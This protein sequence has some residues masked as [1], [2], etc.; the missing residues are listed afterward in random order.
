MCTYMLFIPPPLLSP[1]SSSHM[2]RESSARLCQHPS[3]ACPLSQLILVKE[4]PRFPSALTSPLIHDR[5]KMDKKEGFQ[6]TR[7]W[8]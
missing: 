2:H 8:W 4:M 1:T 5:F 7:M 6:E 3:S